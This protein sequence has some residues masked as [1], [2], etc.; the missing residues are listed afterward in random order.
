MKMNLPC[1]VSMCSLMALAGTATAQEKKD[2]P[3][4]KGPAVTQDRIPGVEQ[5]FVPGRQRGALG[6]DR[7]VP[8]RVFMEAIAELRGDAAPEG[9]ALT[10]EQQKA[11]A[12]LN[13]EFQR[14]TREFATKMRKEM[15]PD[16]ERV[17]RRPQGDRRPDQKD[18]SDE[19][20]G[21]DRRPSPEMMEK[22]Q[23]LRKNA[24][25]PTDWQTKIYT[26]L[27]EPQK[28]FVLGRIEEHEK[29][30]EAKRAEEYVQKRLKAAGADGKP[31][32]ARPAVAGAPGGPD[33]QRE[34]M[35]RILERIAQ[36]P[37]EE[38]ERLLSRL[39][40]ALKERTGDRATDRPQGDR[41]AGRKPAPKIDDVEVPKPGGEIR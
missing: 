31:A 32:D 38:R 16:A 24:P 26:H 28:Q 15:G 40:E 11:I 12:G 18:P 21:P 8:Q 13:D 35:R 22:M 10:A 23:E 1:L 4:L 5:G 29:Q 27:T 2:A 20:A 14:S 6:G 41:P 37:P 39:E 3:P 36:L 30:I 19:M 7:G 17:M 9:L 34:R 25:N 33:M